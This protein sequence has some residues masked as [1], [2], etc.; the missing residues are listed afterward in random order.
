M[1]LQ[2]RKGRY[3]PPFL[4]AVNSQGAPLS[5]WERSGTLFRTSQRIFIG[6][7]IGLRRILGAID[8]RVRSGARLNLWKAYLT[9]S[10]TL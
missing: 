9:Y 2:E 6:T 8:R 1:P 7:K 4:R 10:M 3:A 5:A